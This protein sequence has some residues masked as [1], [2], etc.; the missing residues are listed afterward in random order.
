MPRPRPEL[1]ATRS[2][3]ST[4]P[5]AWMRRSRLV[6]AVVSVLALLASTANAALGDSD[7]NG[8]GIDD[9]VV[10][11]PDEDVAQVDD[12]GSINYL[13]GAAGGITVRGDKVFDQADIGGTV[14]TGDRFGNAL[15]YGDFDDDGFDDVAIGAPT[16]GHNGKTRAGVVYIMYGSSRGPRGRNVQ[17]VSQAGKMAGKNES[18]DFFGAVLAAGD[19]NGDNFDD[20]A[21]GAPGEDVGGRIAS[22]G[23]VV[24]YGSA[25]GIRNAGSQMLTQ[26]GR[27]PGAAEDLDNFGVALAVGDFN[28][29]GFDD[30]GIGAP[31]EDI[32][33]IETVGALTVLYGESSGLNRRGDSFSRAGA[34]AGDSFARALTAGDFNGDGFDD[35]AAGV[36]G[37]DVN[38]AD[39]AGAVVVMSGSASG[40]A[41]DSM[42]EL[43][44]S[45]G[46]P[47]VSE[48]GDEFGKVLASGNFNG[49]N[50]DDL[51]VGSPS[52][53]INALEDAGQVSIVP[54]SASG[55]NVGA[56]TVFNQ[57]GL[58]GASPEPDD[59][60]GA[61]MR[62]GDF[63]N[64]G[65]DDL[66]AASPG[67][68]TGARAH[69]G[70]V[71]VVYGS[72]S[73]LNPGS[74]QK[75]QQGTPGVRGKPESRDF[76]GTGL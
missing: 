10:G 25:S 71:H 65:F 44:Q 50:Y 1:L 73:G 69:S 58:P 76:F 5:H 62:V 26:K 18:G 7:L 12:A 43:T 53:A 74:A 27:V 30:L 61:S 23:V 6:L 19:F 20:L 55:L 3:H 13:R 57:G 9:L 15:A 72:A 16:E 51:A 21:I 49:D 45:D 75:I 48:A 46:L 29:D 31:G 39:D 70:I 17:L 32:G 41:A 11:S 59:E 38:G 67:E 22:G 28:R 8:D 42:Q 63:N 2:T 47:E 52:E 4:N 64:D 24:A 54:G 33:G 14:E 40:L 68:G 56:S 34:V 36:P 35:I 60:L 37:K 66:V